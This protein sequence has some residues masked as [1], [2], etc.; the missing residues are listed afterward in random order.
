MYKAN[1]ASSTYLALQDVAFTQLLQQL[2]LRSDR[3]DGYLR[4][5]VP[6]PRL[7]AGLSQTLALT[8]ASDTIPAT[9]RGTNLQTRF[10]CNDGKLGGP[11]GAAM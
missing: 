11:H 5:D 10:S 4:G 6:H 7:G 9:N 3:D 2:Q 8:E 1:K